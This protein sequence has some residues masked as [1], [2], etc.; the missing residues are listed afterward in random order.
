MKERL[1]WNW[2]EEWHELTDHPN[3]RHR[4]RTN[5][6]INGNPK[7]NLCNPTSNKNQMAWQTEFFLEQKVIWTKVSTLS[8]GRTKSCQYGRSKILCFIFWFLSFHKWNKICLC[9]TIILML[10]LI[11][12]NTNGVREGSEISILLIKFIKIIIFAYLQ[13]ATLV[14]ILNILNIFSA[15]KTQFINIDNLEYFWVL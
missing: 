10:I 3:P 6:F 4:Q 11:Y 9:D 7:S 13:N 8:E 5:M 1:D 14:S 2:N 15:Q 12:N